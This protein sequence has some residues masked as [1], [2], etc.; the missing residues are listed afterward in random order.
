M[1]PEDVRPLLE[2]TNFAHVATL[3]PDGS[4]HSVAVWV[5]TEGDRAFFFTQDGSRK[6]RNLAAD[7]RVAI[8]IVDRANPYRTG[9]LRGR[10]VETRTGDEA[11]ALIDPM[12]ERYTGKPFPI[13]TGRVF[14]V[15]VDR[16]GSMSL[17]FDPPPG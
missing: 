3:L 10:V 4:P 7:A 1:I 15:E 11:F 16:A 2:G 9:W 17:P 14:L 8:S 12:S 13:R 5:G 6:A